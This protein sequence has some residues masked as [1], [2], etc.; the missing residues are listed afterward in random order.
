[1]DIRK[2]T[3]AYPELAQTL[4]A[5]SGQRNVVTVYRPFVE[6]TGSLEAALMLSQL[7][8]WTPRATIKAINEQTGRT[9]TWIAKSDKEFQEELC[10]S[11]HS[12][13]AAR[14]A[15]IKLGFL[16]TQLRKFGPSPTIHYRLDLEILETRWRAWLAEVGYLQPDNGLSESRQPDCPKSDKNLSETRQSLTETTTPTTH[17]NTTPPEPA[18]QG[19][20]VVQ[21]DGGGVFLPLV[22]SF[23]IR[24]RKAR[25][26]AQKAIE[27]GYSKDD[28]RAI[29]QRAQDRPPEHRTGWFIDVVTNGDWSVVRGSR[30]HSGRKRL[31]TE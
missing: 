7:L 5:M 30:S 1:M 31:V 8:Y 28:L 11:R 20:K 3:R 22:Q 13:R 24:G 10:L 19:E 21:A 6:F 14:Q 4:I 15:L 9:E 27:H 25:E 12:V 18:P 16:K 26:T 2:A 23:G 29:W 17:E